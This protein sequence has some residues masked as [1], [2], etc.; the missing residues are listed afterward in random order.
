METKEKII[1]DETG[2]QVVLFTVCW[3]L[4]CARREECLRT[5]EVYVYPRLAG[6][7]FSWVGLSLG[8]VCLTSLLRGR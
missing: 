2:S 7:S 6:A 1:L 8:L 3:Y 5:P 4:K